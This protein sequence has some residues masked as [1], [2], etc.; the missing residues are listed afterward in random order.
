MNLKLVFYDALC[1]TEAFEINGVDATYDDFGEKRDHRSTDD[2]GCGNMQ[3]TRNDSTPEILEKYSINEEDYQEI[4]DKLT[5]G[6]SFGKCG[7]C[8]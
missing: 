7:W 2:Y 6:L 5:E 4:C 3:F 1:E 8:I